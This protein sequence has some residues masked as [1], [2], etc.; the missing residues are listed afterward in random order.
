MVE[1]PDFIER[2]DDISLD[3]SEEHIKNS[4]ESDIDLSLIKTML[5]L[6][7]VLSILIAIH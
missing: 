2:I 4:V 6:T 3:I 1:N 7:I 5:F